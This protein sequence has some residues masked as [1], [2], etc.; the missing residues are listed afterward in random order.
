MEKAVPPAIPGSGRGGEQEASGAQRHK[1]DSEAIPDRRARQIHRKKLALR[2]VTLTARRQHP[3]LCESDVFDGKREG[4][5]CDMPQPLSL[6]TKSD[7]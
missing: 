4:S 1:S 2:G 6:R 3:P 7:A 5:E